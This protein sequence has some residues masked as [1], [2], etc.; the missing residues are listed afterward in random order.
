MLAVPASPTAFSSSS[1]DPTTIT[2]TWTQPAGEVVHQYLITYSF[3]ENDCAFADGNIQVFANGSSRTHTLTG[4]EENSDY[5][6]SIIARN[7]AG[8]SP[9]AETMETTAVAGIA[10]YNS[11]FGVLSDNIDAAPSVPL[12]NL[13]ILST[14]S[15]SITITWGRVPCEDR[16]VEITQYSGRYGPNNNLP[17]SVIGTSNRMFTATG[18]VPRTSYAFE[19]EA[20]HFNPTTF[21]SFRGP[22]ATVTDTMH[23]ST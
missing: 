2:L 1:P 11:V 3:R 22:S 14:T 21:V 10:M 17:I 15:T 19:V 7:T 18:L 4:V 16:N 20:A 8:D 13:R 23:S 5:N 9:P 12:T 6:I